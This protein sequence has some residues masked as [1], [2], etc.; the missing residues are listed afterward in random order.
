[1]DAQMR[2][3]R[4]SEI[5]LVSAFVAIACRAPEDVASRSPSPTSDDSSPV[6]PAPSRDSGSSLKDA[7]TEVRAQVATAE[8]ESA[9]YSGGLVKALVDSRVQ[10]LKQTL[11]MLEQ[12]DKAFTFGL[13]LRYTIDGKA[14]QLPAGAKDELVDI[15]RQLRENE[16]KIHG[17]EAEVAQYSGGLVQALELSTLATMKQTQAMLDQRR[18]AI[19]YELPQYL[20]FQASGSEPASS[21][22]VPTTTAAAPQASSSSDD[23]EVIEVASRPG[24]SNSTWTRFSWKLTIRN[25]SSLPAHFAATIEFRDADGFP[26]DSDNDYNLMVPAFSEQ[27]FTGAKLIDASQVGRISST[28]AK[29]NKRS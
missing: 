17:Q 2:V 22:S 23:W 5:A 13:R 12:R 24:E 19:K 16:G 11:A 25:K 1:M 20:P 7:I 28:A 29:V 10:T 21:A 9:R 6:A 8:D 15:E 3:G 14:F 27:T 26:V 18:L 4:I